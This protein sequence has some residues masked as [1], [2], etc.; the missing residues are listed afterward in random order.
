MGVAIGRK[1]DTVPKI[2][3]HLTAIIFFYVDD[4]QLTYGKHLPGQIMQ[5]C[6]GN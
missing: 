5:E 6:M 1:S 3:E 4:T 2:V